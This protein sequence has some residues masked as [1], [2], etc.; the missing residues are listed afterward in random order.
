MKNCKEFKHS[1]AR[2]KQSES[3]WRTCNEILYAH[4]KRQKKK[5]ETVA[6]KKI[7]FNYSRSFIYDALPLLE[8]GAAV[9]TMR[10]LFQSV[11]SARQ[12]IWITSF[13]FIQQPSEETLSEAK[14]WK[15]YFVTMLSSKRFIQTC[16]NF[17][18]FNFLN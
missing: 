15:A 13:A 7:Q 10:D 8:T 4:T 6:I 18:S 14:V 2:I 1:L 16:R 11:D 9:K 5:Q 17:R 12:S 3:F